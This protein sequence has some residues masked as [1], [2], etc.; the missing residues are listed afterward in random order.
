MA[1]VELW[2]VF[3]SLGVPGLTLGVFYMLFRKFE[4]QFSKVP[5]QWVGPIVVLFLI[6][7]AGIIFYALTLWAPQNGNR[8]TENRSNISTTGDNSPV[9]QGTKGDV[10]FFSK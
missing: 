9:I 10:N 8:E 5:R 3:I 2:K 1:Q 7:T 4:W 6:L